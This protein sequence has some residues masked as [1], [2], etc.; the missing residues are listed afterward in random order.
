MKLSD[1][2]QLTQAHY[3]I[4]V[5]LDMLEWTLERYANKKESGCPLILEPEFQ[6]GHVW[7]KEQQIAYCEFILRGGET[8]RTIIFNCR[9]W[10]A[11]FKGPM[12][13]VDGLQR[14]TALRA[15]LKGEVPVFGH[16]L[17]DYE[18]HDVK[19]RSIN[20]TFQVGNLSSYADIL[21][22]YLEM[23]SGGTP[24]TQSEID[25][26]TALWEAEKATQK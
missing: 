21:K 4:S 2:P 17:L 23:N 22:W 12:Y 19:V 11:S 1:I 9:G 10:M 26:V 20:L 25:R 15:M 16:S 6:R 13:L 8:G 24:H 18:D 7:T 3:H 14:I 5:S